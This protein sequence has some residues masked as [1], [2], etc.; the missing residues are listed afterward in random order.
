MFFVMCVL[1]CV[2]FCLPLPCPPLHQHP[3]PPGTGSISTHSNSAGNFCVLSAATDLTVGKIYAAMMIMEYYR[4]SKAKRTQALRDE[5][6]QPCAHS[7]AFSLFCSFTFSSFLY[8]SLLLF[9]SCFLCMNL[10][11]N[12][13]H[14]TALHKSRCTVGIASLTKPK[15]TVVT[16]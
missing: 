16:P 14:E 7:F 6:V 5:Q 3:I 15:M 9:H 11:L 10:S 1:C 13:C 8:R 2:V 12:R 4:Q